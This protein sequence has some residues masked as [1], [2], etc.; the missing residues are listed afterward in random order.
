MRLTNDLKRTLN[1]FRQFP[2]SLSLLVFFLACCS[3][4]IAQTTFPPRPDTIR[5]DRSS[6]TE[7]GPPLTTIEEEMRA[8]RAIKYA[9][10]EH[11][12]NL[13]RAGQI[14]ELGK[15]LVASFKL[16]RSLDREDIRRLDRLEKLTRKIRSEAGGEDN[17]TVL[18]KPPTD[19]D[20]AV[21]RL[22]E[23]SASVGDQFKKTPRQVISAEVI[24]EAN[25]LLEIIKLVRAMLR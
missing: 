17:E 8:K 6:P 21:S 13:A 19:L 14:T 1:V 23:L 4:V 5:A 22:A 10:K 12:E 18:S 3:P 7:D 11:K 24:D 16:K 25:A 2:Q 9:E 20:S 15:E